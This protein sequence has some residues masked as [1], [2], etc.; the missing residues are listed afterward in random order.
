MSRIRWDA[1]GE[2]LYEVGV[3]RGV[4]FPFAGNGTYATGVAWNGLTAVNESPSGAEPTKL[5]ADNI[6][7]LTL[8]SVEELGL[9][10][11]AYT[12]PE[13]FEECDGSKEVKPGVSIGQQ[14]RKHFGFVYRSLIGNDEDGNDHGYKLHIIYD[15]L[16]SPTEKGHSTVN[17]SPD[18]SPFSWTVSTTPVDMGVTGAKP[19]ACITIDSTKITDTILK[20]IEDLIY[21][22]DAGDNQEATEPTLPTPAQILALFPNVGG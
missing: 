16:A 7:Y 2:K 9:T 19:S 6:N 21:G 15:C 1:T 11:E 8:M 20:A 14:T 4:L 13:E 22:K 5:Y 17:D 3:D 18:V 10:I 12:Y